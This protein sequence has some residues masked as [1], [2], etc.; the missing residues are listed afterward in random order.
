[1][2]IQEDLIRYESVLH[3]QTTR[4]LVIDRAMELIEELLTQQVKNCNLGVVGKRYIS[5]EQSASLAGGKRIDQAEQLIKSKLSGEP[6]TVKIKGKL[7][8]VLD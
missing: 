4:E 5:F 7:K 8:V 2:N 3:K 1:M 6:Q